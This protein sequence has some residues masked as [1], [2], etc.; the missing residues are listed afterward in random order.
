MI[1]Y[2]TGAR[3]DGQGAPQGFLTSLKQIFATDKQ[4]IKISRNNIDNIQLELDYII[5]SLTYVNKNDYTNIRVLEVFKEVYHSFDKIQQFIGECERLRMFDRPT[6]TQVVSYIH[7][8]FIGG[9]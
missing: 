6:L 2:Y 5:Q 3:D 4:I 1:L 8:Q 9:R 7:K